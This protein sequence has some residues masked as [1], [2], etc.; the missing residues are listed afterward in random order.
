MPIPALAWA[1]LPSVVSAATSIANRPKKRDYVPN[2]SYIDKYIANLQ[3]RRAGR[4]VEQMAMRPALRAIGQQYGRGIRQA[5]YDAAKYGLTGS[6]IDIQ[7]KL[8]LSEQATGALTQASEQ[9][10][11]MQYRENRNIEDYIQQLTMQKGQMQEEGTRA[12]R[13][14]KRQSNADIL[15]SLAQMGATVGAGISQNIAAKKAA[16]Q[17]LSYQDLADGIVSGE[18]KPADITQAYQSKQISVEQFDALRTGYRNMGTQE[19]QQL[20]GTINKIQQTLGQEAADS[21]MEMIKNKVDPDIALRN[22]NQAAEQAKATAEQIQNMTE[23]QYVDNLNEM[24]INPEISPDKIL[25][26]PAKDRV[27]MNARWAAHDKKVE[28]MKQAEAEQIKATEEAT[29]L[30][31][32]TE[33]AID[34][35]KIGSNSL[36]A[37]INRQF[38]GTDP[39]VVSINEYLSDP[40]ELHNALLDKNSQLYKN[41]ESLT[42]KLE[43]SLDVKGWSPAMQELLLVIKSEKGTD[44]AKIQKIRNAI[45]NE[46]LKVDKLNVEAGL[47][48]VSGKGSDAVIDKAW[49]N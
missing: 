46:F 11:M 17:V 4:E 14:A 26:V 48:K 21:Y 44:E 18:V 35:A 39:S 1:I 6:G 15:G 32:K 40:V 37:G 2:T 28:A 23:A 43:S 3:G 38:E 7:Q 45:V 25:E 8:S 12:F 41:I 42:P 29:K 47:T 13:Q 19:A 10:G 24:V 36:I 33:T 30:Q 49:G 31:Q 20:M 9:A 5:S 22:V 27:Q 16:G 34:T